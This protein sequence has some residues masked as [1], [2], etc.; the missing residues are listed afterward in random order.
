MALDPSRNFAVVFVSGTISDSATSANL[1]V[2]EGA[3]L[4]QPSTEGSYNL[5]VW[6]ATDYE[7]AFDDPY[8]EVI[9]VGARSTDTLSSLSRGQEGTSAVAH[10]MAGKVYKMA[11]TLTKKTFDEIPACYEAVLD[12]TTNSYTLS[13]VRLTTS[14]R[15]VAFWGLNTFLPFG[16]LYISAQANGSVTV[17][18]NAEEVTDKNIV[19]MVYKW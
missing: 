12:G 10:N 6:N 11:L 13:N 15:C 17:A 18:S 16:V 2:G 19:I 5:V 4:P 7:N 1:Q 9:R 8:H 3:K 14:S